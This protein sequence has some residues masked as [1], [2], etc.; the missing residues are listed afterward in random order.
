MPPPEPGPLEAGPILANGSPY[1]AMLTL[2]RLTSG[3]AMMVGSIASF[4]WRLFSTASGGVNC[5]SAALGRRP[6]LAG[7]GE[8]SP[9]PPPP[10]DGLLSV[11]VYGAR[12]TGVKISPLSFSL[13][14]T[15]LLVPM[16]NNNAISPTWIRTDVAK[17]P[18]R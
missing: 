15:V 8:L 2:G 11:G 1:W 18:P 5:F 14:W 7:S 12:S 10:P 17:D 4:G 6:L 13:F 16:A 9:P 3:G